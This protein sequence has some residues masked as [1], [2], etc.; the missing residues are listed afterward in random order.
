VFDFKR[1]EFSAL[2]IIRNKKKL[3]N[4]ALVELKILKYLRDNDVYNQM[5]IV[6]IKDFVIFRNHV[7]NSKPNFNPNPN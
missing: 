3:Y 7:V 5:N 2:K 6:K 4:Q 1:K